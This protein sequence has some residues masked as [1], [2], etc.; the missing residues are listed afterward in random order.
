MSLTCVSSYFPVKNKHN[1]KYNEW[2][3]N[4]L[5]V[6]CPYVFFTSKNSI[7]LIKKFRKN[8]PTYYIV[9]EIEDFYTYKYK[10]KM[11][12][13][14]V[15]CPSVELNLIWNEKIFMLQ[16][17]SH[18]NP[19]KSEWFHW[20]DAGICVYRERCPSQTE[21]TNINN[22]NTLPKDKLIYSQSEKYDKTLISKTNYYHHISGTFL[23]HKNFIDFFLTF[24]KDY[25]DKL[26]DR[27]NI[28]TDQVIHT[29]IHKDNP[30]MYF[31]LC[32]GY[33]K[34]SEYLFNI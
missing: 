2:F 30:E 21:F 31:K 9:C 23:I 25:L 26:I 1:D 10:D 8:L 3:K 16:T 34:I 32:N 22:L 7:D 5:S 15:H 6:N 24:Y 14:P 4:T 18:I 29:H 17:A 27:N 33:G 28:W 11:I 13:H 20:I 12:S 19:F